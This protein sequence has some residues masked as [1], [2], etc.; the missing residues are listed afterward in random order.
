MQRIKHVMSKFFNQ[1]TQSG[2]EDMCPKFEGLLT[3]TLFQQ[4][5][6]HDFNLYLPN[7]SEQDGPQI[8]KKY[9]ISHPFKPGENPT[10]KHS[11]FQRDL[12]DLYLPLESCKSAKP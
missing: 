7:P 9:G 5:I 2:V 10:K 3:H 1:S 4:P 12:E 11:F 6:H 8:P